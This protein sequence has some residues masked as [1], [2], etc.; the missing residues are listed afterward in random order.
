MTTCLDCGFNHVLNVFLVE[1]DGGAD[2]IDDLV[3]ECPKCESDNC[4]RD[5]IAKEKGHD[6]DT[7]GNVF[8][9]IDEVTD[10]DIQRGNIRKG[11]TPEDN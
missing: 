9:A 8:E 2:G 4:V 6:T 1:P 5:A 7:L 3:M 10:T 11:G